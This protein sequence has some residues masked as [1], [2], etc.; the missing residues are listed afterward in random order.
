[1]TTNKHEPKRMSDGMRADAARQPLMTQREAE[2]ASAR[3]QM[4]L[5][6][7]A[8]HLAE[9]LRAMGGSK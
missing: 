2:A 5:A 4:M 7:Q 3:T 6:E 8:A 9:V 1:M